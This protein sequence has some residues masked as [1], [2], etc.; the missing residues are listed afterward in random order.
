[1][2][3]TKHKW[4]IGWAVAFGGTSLLLV[5]ATLPAFVDTE[6]RSLL[7]IAFSGACHQIA[8]RSPHWAGEQLAVC[9][10]CYGIYLA[11]PIAALSF[12]SMRRWDRHLDRFA[13]LLMSTAVAV[14]GADWLGDIVGIWNNTAESRLLTGAVFGVIAG[15]FLSRALVNLFKRAESGVVK[16]TTG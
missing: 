6:F 12:L 13:P 16:A 11:M 4:V 5:L 2:F 10:R 8:E 9:H 3:Q 15:Y 1:M 14:P 7:M